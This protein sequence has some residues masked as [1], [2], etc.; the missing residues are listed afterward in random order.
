MNKSLPPRPDLGQLKKQAKD[1]LND[2]RANR[3]EAVAR[4][5]ANEI[6][7]FALADAQRTVA[8]EYGFA[9]W[10]RLKLHV[11]TR[12]PGLAARELVRAAVRGQHENV[13][14]IL[15]EFPRL[16]RASINVAAALG[17]PVGVRDW[18]Q[19]DPALATARSREVKW[20]PLLFVCVGRVGGD[21]AARAE[22]VRLLLA[23]GAD[24]NEYWTEDGVPTVKLPALCGATGIN[25]YPQTARELLGAGANPNDDESVYHAAEHAHLASLKVLKEFGA[26]LS[27]SATSGGGSTP[28]YFI[29]EVIGGRAEREAGARWLLEQG[30]NPNVVCR[31]I[32]ETALHAAVRRNYSTDMIELLL[33]RGADASCRRL[34]GRTALALAVRG[35]H[36]NIAALLR[37]RGPTDGISA[38]D[39]FL[40][41]CLRADGTQARA[42]LAENPGL[43]DQ[44][45]A[46]DR[47]MVTEAAREG[48]S[49]AIVLMQELGFDVRLPDESGV[50]PLHSA[51]WNGRL[52]AVRALIAAGADINRPEQRFNA[53]PLGWVM[54]GSQF[55]RDPEGDYP[56]CAE[57]LLGAG[58]MAPEATFGSV[59]VKAVLTGHRGKSTE[60]PGRVPS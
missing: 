41:A 34:D 27:H 39:R 43:L 33:T 52:A 40:G 55:N 35:G 49:A 32:Q 22:C 31:A 12:G 28:L 30:A 54:H 46:T 60:N 50:T 18:L 37:A 2:I 45:P 25:D 57:T 26:D 3:P 56:G 16:S 29:F 20:T 10:A 47:Q 8:R 1:L 4:V 42:L 23:A 19:H 11:E 14:Q 36:E 48:R 9:S 17:D 15:R 53:T 38:A 59:E 21:D 24:A 13:A 51:G 5:S 44:L 6:A 7:Q 58:A